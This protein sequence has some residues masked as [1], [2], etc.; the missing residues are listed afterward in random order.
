MLSRYNATTCAL[1]KTLIRRRHMKKLDAGT[2]FYIPLNNGEFGFGYI[3]YDN[4]F[5]IVNIFDFKS[6]NY[7]DISTAFGRPLLIEGWLIDIVVFA[8]IKSATFP[9][10]ELLR[11]VIYDNPKH[12][13]NPI[14]IYGL[15]SRLK[16]L[17]YITG[18][19]ADGTS[20]DVNEY[21]R[22]ITRHCDYY[23]TFVRLKISG[24][25]FDDL[26]FDEA[27]NSYIPITN[28]T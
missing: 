8:K 1:N 24:A 7:K 19:I 5:L 4:Q 9:K 21:P 11:K 20:D 25:I 16:R 2:C 14:V 15:P 13:E 26:W 22:F 18:D 12:P 6:D 10:W 28:D 27:S 23:S 17:N 3:V